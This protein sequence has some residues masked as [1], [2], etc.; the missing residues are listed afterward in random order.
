[1]HDSA[2]RDPGTDPVLAPSFEHDLL[3]IACRGGECVVSL[4]GDWT[5]DC[6]PPNIDGVLAGDWSALRSVR[7]DTREL[8]EW[9]STL[10]ILL[11]KISDAA[12]AANTTIDNAALPAGV[13]G[14][15]RLARAVP[16]RQDVK[17]RTGASFI[18]RIGEKALF[19]FNQTISMMAFFGD[20]I[21]AIGRFVIGRARYR[22]SDLIGFIRHCGAD[23]FG[24][25]SVISILVGL[26]LAFVGSVQLALVGAEIYVAD[27]VAIGMLRQM[28]ALMTAVIIAGRTGAAYAAQLGSMQLNEE[29]DAFQTLGVSP[30]EFLVVPR[31]IALFVM[32]PLLC[33]YSNLMGVIGGLIVGVGLFDIPFARYLH[34]TQEAATLA[35]LGIGLFMS[36]VFAVIIAVIG[37]YQGLHSGRSSSAVGEA[38][39]AAVVHSIV[40]II[41]ADSLITLVTI[42]LGI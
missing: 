20:L 23:A 28:G 10:V 29:I 13:Q 5:I 33:V 2:I 25:V 26:I 1:M 11:L 41:V 17:G 15:M 3:T 34:Q 39:T 16:E 21:V 36:L 32:M 35:D 22:R 4:R 24:I 8:G 7:F 19:A 12:T 30:L 6:I 27:A 38:A 14:L 40:A 42:E 31:L 9:D 37:C 18:G